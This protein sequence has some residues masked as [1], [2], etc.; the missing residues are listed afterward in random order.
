VILQFWGDGDD[1]VLGERA[2]ELHG[3]YFA[4]L[5]SLKRSVP[6]GVDELGFFFFAEHVYCDDNYKVRM[7]L[8]CIMKIIIIKPVQFSKVQ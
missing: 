2:Y 3:L 5:Y 1:K 8:Q 4:W 7:L 6:D